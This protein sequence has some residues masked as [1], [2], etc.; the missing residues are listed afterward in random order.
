[1]AYEAMYMEPWQGTQVSKHP[2]AQH[3]SRHPLDQHS[4]TKVYARPSD[5]LFPSP[6][7]SNHPGNVQFLSIIQA[8]KPIYK[9]KHADKRGIVDKFVS[10]LHTA[11]SIHATGGR[12]LD[13]VNGQWKQLDIDDAKERC[14]QFLRFLG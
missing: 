2:L 7:W 5:V 4:T 1:M 10:D 3:F 14:V 8:L 6:N 9:S 13:Q 12:L 11:G